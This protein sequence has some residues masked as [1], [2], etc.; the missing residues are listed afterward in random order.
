M[1]EHSNPELPSL[2][3]PPDPAASMDLRS[4]GSG[5]KILGALVVVA[6]AGGIG[7]AVWKSMA[8]RKLREKHVAFMASFKEVEDKEVGPFWACLFGPNTL[9]LKRQ[10][11]SPEAVAAI[12]RA[13]RLLMQSGLPA[14]EAVAR[15]AAEPGLGDRNEIRLLVEFIRTSKRGVVLKRRKRVADHDE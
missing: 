10:G 3:P 15:I 1:S 2:L 13:Y 11:F 8:N 4:G 7:F 9:G 6:I 14:T 12:R 5:G